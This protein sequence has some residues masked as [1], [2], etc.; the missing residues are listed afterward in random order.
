MRYLA[1]TLSIL[2]LLV[3]GPDFASAQARTGRATGTASGSASGATRATGGGSASGIASRAGG[4]DQLEV[5]APA[6]AVGDVQ[7]E[8]ALAAPRRTAD[9][10]RPVRRQRHVHRE[11]DVVVVD[12]SGTAATPSARPFGL[13]PPLRGHGS[14]PGWIARSI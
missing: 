7:A 9:D 3:I 6:Q 10:Q 1:G 4:R 12:I 5:V 13:E 2:A 14:T 11:D 8:R